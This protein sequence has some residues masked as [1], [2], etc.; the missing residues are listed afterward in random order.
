[1]QKNILHNYLK[2]EKNPEQPKCPPR[3]KWMNNLWNRHTTDY[4]IAV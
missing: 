2:E 1:M 3:V 4:H